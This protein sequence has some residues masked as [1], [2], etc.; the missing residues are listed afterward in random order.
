MKESVKWLDENVAPWE[1]VLQ[2]L[3]TTFHIRHK[4]LN[5][6]E[7]KTLYNLLN[8]WSILKHP[9]GYELIVQDFNKMNL[10][11]VTF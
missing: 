2:H 1:L 9:Q 4:D 10:S 5:N 6:I 11:K 7:E 3:S 8:K